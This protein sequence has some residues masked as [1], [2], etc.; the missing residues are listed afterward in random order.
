[1][2]EN[3][4]G[5]GMDLEERLVGG[6][7]R[8][9]GRRH[10]EGTEGEKGGEKLDVSI[11]IKNLLKYNTYSISDRYCQILSKMMN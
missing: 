3:R 8:N 11:S 1:M 6:A 4:K 5:K 10:R 7:E 9:G 2:K